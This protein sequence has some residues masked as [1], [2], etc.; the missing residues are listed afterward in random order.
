MRRVRSWEGAQI[1][2]RRD[3]GKYAGIIF[4]YVWPGDAH[5]REYWLRRDTPEIEYD[6]EGSPKEKNKYLGP[7]GRGNLLYLVPGT[8]PALIDNIT[9]PIAITEGAK[10]TLALYRLSFH[11]VNS[12]PRFLAAG[13]AGVWSFRGKTGKTAGPDGSLRDE[14]GLISD[15]RRITWTRRP[16]FIV[17]DANV[18][19]NPKVAAARRVLTAELKKL[20]AK[21]RW[22][23]LALQGG[24]R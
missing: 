2:G 16:V 15:L 5:C 8:D 24:V 9:V 20:G 19:T 14:Q 21:V 1:V 23:S 7:P 18:E 22:V 6:A 13:L 3:N 12:R 4:P 10:K 11:N 17:F